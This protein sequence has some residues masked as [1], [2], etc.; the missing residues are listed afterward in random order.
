[1]QFEIIMKKKPNLIIKLLVSLFIGYAIW[2]ALTLY[3]GPP[4]YWQYKLNQR[5]L[6]DQLDVN[7]K[8]YSGQ[9]T[10]PVS[11]FR[12]VISQEMNIEDVHKIVTGYEQ[13][14]QCGESEVYYYFNTS[15]DN[16]LKF[17]IYYEQRDLSGKRK[18][19]SVF[20]N[21]EYPNIVSSDGCAPGLLEE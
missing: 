15:D 2:I 1:M 8:D 20:F 13:V 11:Y 4:Y 16:A 17:K 6:A 21:S 14:F 19:L 3:F 10:F 9:Y 7:V 12:T 5:R 18:F